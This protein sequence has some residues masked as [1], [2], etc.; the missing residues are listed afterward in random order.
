MLC[1]YHVLF[2]YACVLFYLLITISCWIWN[3]WTPSQMD[4]SL[5]SPSSLTQDLMV[6][7]ILFASQVR[8]SSTLVDDWYVD[9]LGFLLVNST[10]TL[11]LN[12]LALIRMHTRVEQ[13]AN[14]SLCCQDLKVLMGVIK[15]RDEAMSISGG[16][17]GLV[18]CK[19]TL[20]SPAGN[21]G[22]QSGCRAM[23]I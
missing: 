16:N 7:M 14:K 9:A 22:T 17:L 8:P 18:V 11:I 20:V 21:P 5:F 19:R 1:V 23:E 12:S 2:G 6:S 15:A 4:P 13:N 10:R 3:V